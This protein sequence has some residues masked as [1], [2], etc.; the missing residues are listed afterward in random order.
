MMPLMTEHQIPRMKKSFPTL[1]AS[2]IWSALYSQHALADLASQCMSG[3][4]VYNR[5]LVNGDT[6]QLPVH[7]KAVQSQANYPDSA[8]FTGN[9]NVE[10]GNRVLTAD[11][12]QLHQKQQPGQTD[13]IRTVTAIGNVHYDDNQVILK[14]PRAWSNLNTKDT[15]V[16]NGDYLMVGRQGRGDADKMKQRENNR[17]T[18]LDNGSFT[19][20]LPGDDSWSVVGSEVIQD[21]QEEVAEI[22]NA[23]FH[24]AG[25][26]VFYSPYM[27]LPIGDKR[28]SGFLIPN[29][30]YGNRNGFELITPY[31]WNIA[32]NYDATITPHV[33]TNRGIQWQNEFR[34]LSRFG[35]SVVEFDWLQNDRQY[36]SD[37]LSGKSGYA[38]DDNYNRWL[39]HWMHSGV[40]DQV[41]RIN[42]DYTKVSDQNYFT[43]LDSVY[44]NTTDGYATQKFSLG[45]ATRNWDA[46]L[47]TRQY[48]IFS[49]LANRDVYRA[50]PQLDINFA[51]NDIGPFDLYLYGQAAKFTNVNPNMPDA[52]R[53]HIEP[54]LSLP[55]SNGWASLNTE[56]KLMATHYQQENLD[57]YR[58]NPNNSAEQRLESQRL[59]DNVNRV[60]PQ[61]KTDG[62]MVFERNMD[63]A[64]GYTQTLEPRAQYLYVPY[65]DQST[66]RAYDSTLLQADYAGLFRDRTFSGLD[67]IASAN[68]VSTGVTTRLYDST[69]EERFNASLGQIYYFERPRTG[70]ASTIDQNDDRGSLSW[71]GDSYWK[72][73]D[74]WG[75]RGG[76][77]Y[78]QRLKDFT[79]GDAVLEYRGGGERM[80]QLNYRFASSKY[81]QAMLPTVT[82][83]GFQQGISQIGATASWPLTDR[84]AIVGAYYYD[85]KANQPAD[86]LL[87]LQYNTCCWAVN[88][89]YERKITKWDSNT[90]QSVYDNKIGFSFEL[91]GL[92]SNYGLGT[93]KM[94]KNGI[95]PYQRAF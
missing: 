1:L 59:K 76:A 77:Q 43:D 24:I 36:K 35:F 73:A 30:K 62:K 71:A 28:R 94:L 61:F 82:N 87:G 19:S 2:L 18:I 26:P 67:R 4:P 13:P 25:V 78:D 89:G 11:Q 33:Q 17:Y 54:T 45:Y 37:V 6:S 10:Q 41:W 65:R 40:V 51:K 69:L 9:V 58:N 21:R 15:D 47:S 8:V 57:T 3:V 81:I 88:V 80:F 93:E 74:N 92:S 64:K 46:T 52:T 44:G 49:N 95:L 68:Q 84:W 7:I 42:V 5:P 29:A 90:N 66:I 39:F 48:Q 32:P 31:Y 56:T 20:C 75:I 16:E 85:T 22:W 27:Q 34:N 12:V 91:R 63:W 83:P 23:R 14:G 55:L 38:A 79:L 53:L 50:M 60:M 72:F 70:T 86:Q